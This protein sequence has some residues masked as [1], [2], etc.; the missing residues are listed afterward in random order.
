MELIELIKGGM[1]PRNSGRSS[2]STLE[3][4]L[5]EPPDR[6]NWANKTEFILSCLGYAIGIGNVWRFPYLCYRNGGG[7]F[8]VP[9]LL[10][11]GL[12]GI[13]LFFMETS[14]GQFASTSCITLFNIC[15]LLQGAGLTIVI[16]NLIC[17]A[18]YNVIIS[19]P[20]Y[21]LFMSFQSRVP[22]QD[23]GHEWNTENC[24]K[25]GLE[26]SNTSTSQ[27]DMNQTREWKTPAD[28][29][30]HNKILQISDGIEDQ[31][32]IVWQLLLCNIASWIIVFLCIMK[33]VKSVGKVV[34]FTATFP[35]IILFI[36]FIRGI[37]LP[38]AWEGIRFYITPQW[39]QLGNIKVWADAAVQIFYS[40]GPGWG[41][42]VNMASYNNFK[43]NNKLDSIVIPIV[44]C[45]TSVFA[46]F[47]VFSVLGFMSHQTGVPVSTVATGGPGLAFVTY[48]EAITML[49]LPQLWAFLFFLMLYLLGMD[50][51]FVQIEALISGV[52][53]AYTSL[54]KHKVLVTALSIFVMFLA[55]LSCI[56]NGGMYVLQLLDWYAASISV[57]LTCIVEVIIVGWLYGCSTFVRDLEFM[58][59]EKINLWWRLSWKYI[60]PIILMFIFVTTIAFNTPVTYNTQAYPYWA[61]IVGWFSAVLSMIWIPICIIYR[62]AKSKG[63]FLQRLKANVQATASWGPA[64]EEN[65][66]AWKNHIAKCN[67][68]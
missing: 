40:L 38:G 65:R 67:Q 3:E 10:M 56:T 24:F 4:K 42:I 44:N 43:N 49:P 37:T 2:Q 32:T 14:L 26:S 34:Y 64:L 22:W 39:E 19:Y 8:L 45:G 33:G 41:G 13:P 23:C 68:R 66:I 62:L 28:E 60:T 61:I 1:A 21:F 52:T 31:G 11:L 9:Y 25:L 53:D 59:E 30:F 36:L 6:G 48:P 63:T 54:R 5:Q 15:P 29:F 51:L 35:F 47:V 27:D 17:S 16:V 46:G 12:C 57:I 20:I 58:I 50:S 55:S 7:A 18:Y